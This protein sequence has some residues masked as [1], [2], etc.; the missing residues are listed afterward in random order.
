MNPAALFAA[1]ALVMT[2]LSC[3]GGGDRATSSDDLPN[4]ISVSPTSGGQLRP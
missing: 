2:L 1:C 4:S 3:G